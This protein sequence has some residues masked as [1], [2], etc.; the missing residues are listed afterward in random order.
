[1][2]EKIK[3]LFLSKNYGDRLIA[4]S[5]L[6]DH[7]KVRRFL[8]EFEREQKGNNDSDNRPRIPLPDLECEDTY[9]VIS[10]KEIILVYNYGLCFCENI[11]SPGVKTI[12]HERKN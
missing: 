5:L 10:K 4:C 3:R 7:Y 12:Y 11:Y 1:M 8:R 2:R 9:Y 6:A